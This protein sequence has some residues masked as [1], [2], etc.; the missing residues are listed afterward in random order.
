MA[1]VIA[2][3]PMGAIQQYQQRQTALD[4]SRLALQKGVQQMQDAKQTASLMRSAFSQGGDL[5]QNLQRSSE[6]LFQH[7]LPEQG[8]AMGKEAAVLEMQRSKAYQQQQA[9]QLKQDT[10]Q[11]NLSRNFTPMSVAKFRKSGNFNDLIPNTAATQTEPLAPKTVDLLAHMY[12]A[13]DHTVLS[14]LGWGGT[15]SSNRAAVLERV[16]N[17]A[18][19]STATGGNLAAAGA[20][21]K[22]DQSALTFYNRYGSRLHQLST[23]TESDMGSLMKSA[24]AGVGG[25]IPIFNRWIQKGRRAAGS[26]EIVGF[27]TLLQTVKNDYARIMSGPSSNAQ[28]HATAMQHADELINNAQTLPQLKA[29]LKSMQIDINNERESADSTV[30]SLRSRLQNEY[31]TGGGTTRTAPDVPAPGTVMDGYRFKGGDP[32]VQA[33]WEPAQ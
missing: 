28:I 3:N 31:G 22:A 33:N 24:A 21:F 25:S 7:G 2:A 14:G 9:N 30:N 5:T 11:V 20:A 29:A 8:L 17:L 4:L 32:S 13:G 10:Y 26:P 15:G 23:K 12:I 1:Q 27:D 16:S 18:N 19:D 6:A